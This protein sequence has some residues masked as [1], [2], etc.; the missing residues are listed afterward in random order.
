MLIAFICV[1][2]VFLIFIVTSFFM[3]RKKVVLK[4]DDKVFT[5]LNSTSR[6]HIF[7]DGKE[8]IKAI[9]PELIA[10]VEYSI[11]L[12]N[13][14]Y[15]IKCKSNKI[16][17]VLNVEVFKDGEKIADNKKDKKNQ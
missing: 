4:V 12:D 2:A 3:T 17:T 13:K 7:V 8:M 5:I 9:L 1:V 10:G 16:G 11:D 6:L 15:I 14:N